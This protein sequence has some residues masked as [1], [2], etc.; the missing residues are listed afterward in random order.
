MA[1]ALD[2]VRLKPEERLISETDRVLVVMSFAVALAVGVGLFAFLGFH[3]YLALTNQT[4]MEWATGGGPKDEELRR[5]GKFRRNPYDM[6]RQRNWEQLLGYR[7]S[8]WRWI[9]SWSVRSSIN[10][11]LTVIPTVASV[12]RE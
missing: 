5:A 4:T 11:D 3:V 8:N 10:E 1:H 9:F 6:G 7:I 2:W 12:G